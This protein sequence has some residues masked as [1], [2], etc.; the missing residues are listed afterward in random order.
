MTLKLT[1]RKQIGKTFGQVLNS[2]EILYHFNGQ[3]TVTLNGDMAE[4]TVYCIT[5]LINTVDDKKIKTT[6]AIHYKDEYIRENGKWFISKRTSI[7]DWTER[8]TLGQ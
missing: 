8:N 6:M 1:G 2:N 3:N 7:F 4:G 5:Y